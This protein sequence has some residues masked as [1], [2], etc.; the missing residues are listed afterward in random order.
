M[1]KR[2][3]VLAAVSLAAV[4]AEA[5]KPVPKDFQAVFGR[6]VHRGAYAVV[7]QEGIPT[8]PVHGADGKQ[9]EAYYSVDVK[10]GD[11][12]P[13][14]GFMDLN[15][16]QTSTLRPGELME[17]VD[18]TFKDD[19]RIDVRLVS[20][21]PHEVL[22]PKTGPGLE[23]A[24][25]NFKFFFPFAL[26]SAYDVAAALGYVERYLQVFPAL[27]AARAFSARAFPARAAAGAPGPTM[28]KAEIKTGMTPLEVLDALGKPQSEVSSG[29]RSK[30][31]YPTLTV[32][33]ENGRV[34][35]VQF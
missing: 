22:R 29:T 6:R 3:M 2:V 25:T 31:T 27:D 4:S 21:E 14:S 32:V 17:V 18:V 20:V 28:V 23:P 24:S 1:L 11:W 16:V 30:W 34:K 9:V 12:K 26:R 7:T 5:G 19:G 10:G 35:D 13:S 15:Q 33:F 8:T